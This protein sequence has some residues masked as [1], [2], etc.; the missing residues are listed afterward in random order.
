MGNPLSLI[1]QEPVAAQGIAIALINLLIAFQIVNL[2][3]AQIGAIN[4]FLAAVFAYL[5]RRSVTPLSNPRNSAGQPL[6]VAPASQPTQVP[7]TGTN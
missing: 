5:V 2:T 1:G 4:I 7:A 3:D 6:V